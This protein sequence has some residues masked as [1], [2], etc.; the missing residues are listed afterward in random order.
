MKSEHSLAIQRYHHVSSM[1][2]M[3][4]IPASVLSLCVKLG[5]DFFPD[6]FLGLHPPVA[7]QHFGCSHLYT[8]Q[9]TSKG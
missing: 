9:A 6:F 7:I 2:I 1:Y 4:S 5:A 8:S 3:P